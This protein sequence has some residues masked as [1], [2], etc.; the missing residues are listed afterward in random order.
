MASNIEGQWAVIDEALA[1]GKSIGQVRFMGL[2]VDDTQ[3]ILDGVIYDE[4]LG[5]WVDIVDR[6]E[7]A[8]DYNRAFV[9]YGARVLKDKN[10]TCKYAMFG[11]LLKGKNEIMAMPIDLE[12]IKEVLECD[13]YVVNRLTD[14]DKQKGNG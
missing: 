6:R 9:N 5:L 7:Y 11:K 1:E 8:A 14:V 10:I 3:I 12:Q 4:R 2:D 13:G